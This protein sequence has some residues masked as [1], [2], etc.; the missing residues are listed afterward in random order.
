M[1]GRER[2][3]SFQLPSGTT[4]ERDNSYN[5]TTVGNIFYNTDISN[6][7]IRHVDPSNSLDWRDLVVNNKEQID[8]SGVVSTKEIRAKDSN[9][10]KLYN[11][12]GSDGLSVNDNGT[13]NFS[14]GISVLS[15]STN[16]ATDDEYCLVAN[17]EGIASCAK[18]SLRRDDGNYYGAEL[19]GGLQI[20]GSSAPHG[21]END[22]R[23]AIN[24]VGNGTPIR[25]ISINN[26]GNVGI[27]DTTP[28]Q[29]LD[30]NGN[31]QSKSFFSVNATVDSGI[32][33]Q[34]SNFSGTHFDVNYRLERSPTYRTYEIGLLGDNTTN[35]NVFAI[36]GYGGGGDDPNIVFGLNSNGDGEFARD[37]YVGRD[38]NVDG[39]MQMSNAP[40]AV[41]GKSNGRVYGTFVP[42][43]ILIRE[44]STFLNTSNGRFTVPTGYAGYYLFTY[45]GLGGQ[46]ERSPNTR[47][48][49]NG[50]QQEWGASHVNSGSYTPSRW[51]LSCQVIFDLN[52]GDYVELK[53]VGGSLYGSNA[54]HSTMIAL[55]L[56][57]K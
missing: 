19:L 23:F 29:K 17:A 52:E 1:P 8:L 20:T 35:G 40:I 44:P 42:N 54:A 49:K 37:L 32:D 28:S 26:V 15:G 50:V 55:Y 45:T 21:L 41:V 25:R 47:W 9:G 14:K 46:G 38:L 4:A 27:G 6:V 13:S 34:L 57:S 53:R 31:T 24:T 12:G 22:E 18:I 11:D 39:L 30:V 43:V 33:N 3:P 56:F 16:N 36:G 51:G 10:L 7:E 2:V 5:L 48:F